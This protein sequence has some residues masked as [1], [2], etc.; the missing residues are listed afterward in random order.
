[1]TQSVS[2]FLLTIHDELRAH[3]PS[4]TRAAIAIYD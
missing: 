2:E 3:F 1:M 4:L